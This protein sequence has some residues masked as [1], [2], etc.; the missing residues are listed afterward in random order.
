MYQII[1]NVLTRGDYDLSAITQKIN[2]VWAEGQITDE[3]HNELLAIARHK[4]KA[5]N[6]VDVIVKLAELEKRIRMLEENK[7][8]TPEESVA[9]YPEFQVGK[10]YYNG[11]KCSFN[12]ANYTCVAPVGVTCVW[13]PIDYPTYWEKVV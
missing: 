1:K 10:W 4:A 8:E 9:E 2:A 11:D 7:S 3:E 6:S 13:S 5:G 12:G